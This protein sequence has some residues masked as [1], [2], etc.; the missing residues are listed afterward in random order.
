MQ[1]A[2]NRRRSLLESD[3]V[4]LDLKWIYVEVKCVLSAFRIAKR[5]FQKITFHCL[6]HSAPEGHGDRATGPS[7]FV[8]TEHYGIILFRFL[9]RLNNDI[10]IRY[11][12]EARGRNATSCPCDW[13]G[14]NG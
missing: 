4:C 13:R 14:G 10:G 11:R 12:A 5:L 9:D 2:S 1:F 3:L 6:C 8:K 7:C